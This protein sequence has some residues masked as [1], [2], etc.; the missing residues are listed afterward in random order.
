M[1]IRVDRDV[2]IRIDEDDV[3]RLKDTKRLVQNFKIGIM[4]FSLQIDIDSGVPMSR[5]DYDSNG[6]CIFLGTKDK[7]NLISDRGAIDGVTI[8][9][10]NIQVDRWSNEKRS[11]H[12]DLKKGSQN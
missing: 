12:E 5:V 11:R 10:I 6:V 2:R 9:D 8:D 7:S 3:V 4:R 1:N